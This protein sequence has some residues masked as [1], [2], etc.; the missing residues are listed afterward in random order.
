MKSDSPIE[1]RQTLHQILDA[2]SSGN[3]VFSPTGKPSDRVVVFVHG[4]ASR[5]REYEGLLQTIHETTGADVYAPRYHAGLYSDARPDAV[6]TDLASRVNRV[7]RE[8]RRVQFVAHS[9]GAVFLRDAFI[10]GLGA[11]S[12]ST[13][14][15]TRLADGAVRMLLLAASSRGYRPTDW[16]QKLRLELLGRW[17][18]LTLCIVALAWS[19]RGMAVAA[20]A[21]ESGFPWLAWSAPWAYQIAA[22]AIAFLWFWKGRNVVATI[23][24][25]VLLCA[26]LFWAA[27]GRFEVHWFAT[28]LTTIGTLVLAW[29]F[30]RE[31]WAVWTMAAVA[32]GVSL[33]APWIADHPLFAWPT[34][35]LLFIPF[36]L[37]PMRSRLM[38]EH[39]LFGA[40]WIAGVRLKWIEAFAD[41]GESS[42]GLK[43]PPIVHL[44]G[45]EDRFVG[46]DDHVELHHFED[47]VEVALRGVKHNDFNVLAGD[48][49]RERTAT[50]EREVKK[51]RRQRF[52]PQVLEAVQQAVAE[53]PNQIRERLRRSEGPVLKTLGDRRDVS[54]FRLVEPATA[55][56]RMKGFDA[57]RTGDEHLVFLV[58]G[59]RDFADWQDS[60]ATKFRETASNQ[61]LPLIDVVQVRYGY[62]SALQFLLS[63][64]RERA[65]KS[66]VDL[67]TQTKA[68]YPHAICHAAAHSNGTY[69]VGEAL[70]NHSFVRLRNVYLAGSVL[71]LEFMWPGLVGGHVRSDRAAQDWPVGVLCRILSRIGRVPILGFHY[72]RLGPGGVDGFATT[73][74][75][76]GKQ[77]VF[78][79][80]YLP[81]GHGEA[82]RPKYHDEIARFV[83]TGE[84][85]ITEQPLSK[86][87]DK[88]GLRWRKIAVFVGLIAIILAFLLPIVFGPPLAVW[89]I[90][91][92][93]ITVFL[94][95]RLGM[96]V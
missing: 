30:C 2:K 81:G 19:L 36:A 32:L 5:P 38:L 15:R 28:A 53:E 93:A 54:A 87:S 90:A 68:R 69:V 78:E 61:G 72:R 1:R 41:R 63:G 27:N 35:L 95:V 21:P 79:N 31:R 56:T 20:A 24:P 77:I 33:A 73:T 58:H 8:Y 55:Q 50:E 9:M 47:A 86:L 23:W 65:T 46:D 83:L 29:G 52:I 26:W 66:F 17:F 7:V 84:P 80:A 94:L 34:L 43:P 37:Y 10:K 88:V 44:F 45:E 82:L 49:Q 51:S 89:G 14:L 96:A 70:R 60:L 42:T 22:V 6:S 71:S 75:E 91:V 11:Q 92:G 12:E 4:F 3:A 59:I 25:V 40:S 18:W 85:T 62:F 13:P 48:L 39:L 16:R 64:E 67:Y 57:R 74:D 76:A